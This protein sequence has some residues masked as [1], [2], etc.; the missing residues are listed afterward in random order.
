MTGGERGGALKRLWPL[1]RLAVTGA[2]LVGLLAKLSPSRLAATISDADPLYLVWTALLLLLVQAL[3]V[4]KWHALVR[5]RGMQVPAA[6]LARH[7]FVG[8][9][10]TNVLPTSIGGDLYRVVR[11]QRESGAPVA[12]VTLTVLYERATG[13]AAMASLGATG[14]AY[15]LAG[16]RAGALVAAGLLPMFL[17]TALIIDRVPLPALLKR[18]R[19][20]VRDRA[21]AMLL[22][23]LTAFSLGIQVLYVS[24][25]AIAGRAFGLDVSWWYWA[26]ATASV[27]LATLLPVSIGGLGVRESGYA[28]V[29]APV[30]AKAAAAASVGFSL[31]ALLAAVSLLALAA[32]EV[33]TRISFRRLAGSALEVPVTDP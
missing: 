31:G 26:L 25:I 5:A 29:L 13:F 28:A 1:V 19:R 7:F 27:A 30:G 22:L 11:V 18:F 15:H 20:L 4:V 6:G 14:A 9:L 23:R 33:A 12:D 3:V 8:N 32:L 10:L 17:V 24:A 21:E 16:V 2:L